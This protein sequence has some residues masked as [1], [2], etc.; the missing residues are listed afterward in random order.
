MWAY[1]G[2]LPCDGWDL[3]TMTDTMVKE[4]YCLPA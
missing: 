1:I 2:N 4:A 3:P